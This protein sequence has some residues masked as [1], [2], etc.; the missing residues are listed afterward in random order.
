MKIGIFVA[1]GSVLVRYIAFRNIR[2]PI[3]PLKRRFSL[4][5]GTHIDVRLIGFIVY[6]FR[7]GNNFRFKVKP[8]SVFQLP[9]VKAQCLRAVDPDFP[10]LLP[11]DELDRVVRLAV[12]KKDSE[13]VLFQAEE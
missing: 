1:F 8:E 12:W 11:V 2:W 13:P 6:D 7:V 9:V 5:R 4:W 3:F 10:D